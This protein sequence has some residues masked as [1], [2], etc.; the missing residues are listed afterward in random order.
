MITSPGMKY[1]LALIMIFAALA[2]ARLLLVPKG[3]FFMQDELRYRYSF[4]F[5][6]E[7]VN[8]NPIE[9]LRQLFHIYLDA[10]P[11]LV[12]FNLPTAWLQVAFLVLTGIKTEAPVSLTI[13]SVVQV[14]VS[15]GISWQLFRLIKRFSGSDMLSIIGV[16]THGLLIN[17]NLYL[18]HIMPYDTAL[19]IYLWWTNW[20]LNLRNW[21]SWQTPVLM[22][23]V[24]VCLYLI[25]PN[26]YLFGLALGGLTTFLPRQGWFGRGLKIVITCS[27]V[28]IVVEILSRMLGVSWWE[29][30]RSIVRRLTVGSSE[31]TL[32]FGYKYLW[33]VEGWIGKLLVIMFSGFLLHF[34]WKW[35][36]YDYKFR[37]LTLSMVGVY[38]F[39]GFSGWWGRV[40]YGRSMHMFFWFVILG[41]M[42]LVRR[43][44][45]AA[46]GITVITLISFVKWYPEYLRLQYPGDILYQYCQLDCSYQ[47]SIMNESY[48]PDSKENQP[49]VG[50][51]YLGVNFGR[52]FFPDEGEYYYDPREGE[53]VFQASHPINFIGY[54]FESLTINQRK[55][56]RARNYQMRLYKL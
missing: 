23:L 22:G 48:A 4:V 25:Y 2:M 36:E 53:L 42:M 7:L 24:I 26:Y 6:R 5:I 13:P 40:Y 49:M 3:H 33:L 30:S 14:A 29:V 52:V 47:V 17:T 46:I 16:I 8:L 54:Q 12:I 51:R 43:F 34:L 9:A 37:L 28:L 31:E 15:L 38:L 45:I 27:S 20:L 10:R 32:I 35:R 55:L 1:R 50:A 18:R 19:V 44:K 41:V 11:M 39:H 56:I 21:R